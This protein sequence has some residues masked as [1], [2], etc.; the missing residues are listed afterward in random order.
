MKKVKVMLMSLLVLSA[1]GGA[2]AFKAKKLSTPLFC[3][4]VQATTDC[5]IQRQATIVQAGAPIENLFCTTEH[6]D[7][8]STCPLQ[9]FD[10]E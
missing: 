10:E 5:S 3:S 1:V 9:A 4:N 8:N 7:D 2:L 6:L